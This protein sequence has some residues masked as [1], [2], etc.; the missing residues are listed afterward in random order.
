MEHWM[1]NRL[2]LRRPAWPG[3][4]PRRPVGRDGLMARAP[5]PKRLDQVRH[6]LGARHDRSR[7]EEVYVMWIKRF[8]FFHGVLHPA[9]VAQAVREAGLTQR[10]TCHTFRHSF[11]RLCWPT[12]MTFAPYRS[13]WGIRT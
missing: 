3:S 12:G 11:G 4:D 7:T 1:V 13:C 8:I 5:K 2:V 9:A 6:A 10:A